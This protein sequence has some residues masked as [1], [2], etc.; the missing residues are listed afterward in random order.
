M[1]NIFS[2]KDEYA[3]EYNNSIKWK[4]IL[5][6]KSTHLRKMWLTFINNFPFFGGFLDLVL[7]MC[8]YKTPNAY[9]LLP[10]R[11]A[12]RVHRNTGGKYHDKVFNFTS[13]S[14]DENRE[15]FLDG[16][17]FRKCPQNICDVVFQF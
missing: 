5:Y 10:S 13:D 1:P 15:A 11:I 14:S 9:V 7:H 6:K 4:Q 8:M 17:V 16:K 2:Q 12:W 3:L